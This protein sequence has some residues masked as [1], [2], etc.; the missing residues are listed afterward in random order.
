MP[1]ETNSEE[2]LRL[3]LESLKKEYNKETLLR[4]QQK[5]RVLNPITK[6]KVMSKPMDELFQ[7]YLRDCNNKYTGEFSILKERQRIRVVNLIRS[8][9][10]KGEADTSRKRTTQQ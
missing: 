5:F 1:K 7:E 4:Y 6:S 8:Y 10:F 2:I 3:T 9:M